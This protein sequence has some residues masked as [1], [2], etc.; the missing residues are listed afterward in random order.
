MSVAFM[1]KGSKKNPNK[2]KLIEEVGEYYYHSLVLANFD[3]VRAKTIFDNPAHEIAKS[4]VV[5]AAHNFR[6]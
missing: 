2:A 4:I 3:P 1:P 6:E 5:L